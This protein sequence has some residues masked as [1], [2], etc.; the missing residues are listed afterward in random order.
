MKFNSKISIIENPETLTDKVRIPL[1]P[2]LL[3]AFLLHELTSKFYPLFINAQINEVDI[4]VSDYD[5]DNIVLEI[6]LHESKIA[7]VYEKT[8]KLPSELLKFKQEDLNDMAALYSKIESKIL[9][10]VNIK[11]TSLRIHKKRLIDLIST[12]C[13]NLEKYS[14]LQAFISLIEIFQKCMEDNLL[15]IYPK[16]SIF[17][18]VN[19]FFKILDINL[20][21]LAK[22][23]IDLIKELNLFIIF[24]D[25][26][27]SFLSHI[28]KKEDGAIDVELLQFKDEIN[29]QNIDKVSKELKTTGLRYL[30]LNHLTQFIL[31]LVEY[32]IPVAKE[33]FKLIIQELIYGMRS[34]QL[35]WDI[36][37]KPVLYNVLL[38]WILRLMGYNLNLRK[39]SHWNIPDFFINLIISRIGFNSS[40]LFIITSTQNSNNLYDSIDYL[41][42]LDIVNGKINRVSSINKEKINSEIL[43]DLRDLRLSLMNNLGIQADLMIKIDQTLIGEI[44]NKCVINFHKLSH[45]SLYK[46]L[47]KFKKSAYFDV[48]PEFPEVLLLKKKR[49]IS[50]LKICLSVFIDRHEF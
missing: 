37:P 21:K 49:F 46:I 50:F 18:F 42:K 3:D 40:L 39:I 24:N 44:L 32:E 7:G 25:E 9:E 10:K 4:I 34:I 41:I 29:Y 48:F 22:E 35:E 43:S 5:I 6:Y 47:R 38:R 33:E 16:S 13:R 20:S 19:D 36:S 15:I 31:D 12:H 30:N 2:I 14:F 23:L 8:Q 17:Q 11:I 45:L 28:Y 27:F 1:T 26:D